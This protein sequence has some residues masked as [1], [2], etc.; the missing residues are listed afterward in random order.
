MPL[1]LDDPA[2]GL[3]KLNRNRKLLMFDFDTRIDRKNSDSHKWRKY[4]DRDII[5]MW[6]ADMDFAAP[7]AVMEALHRRVA[8]GIFGYGNPDPQLAEAITA[9]LED[10]FGWSVDPEWIVWLPGL[11]TGLNVACRSAGRLGSGVV[12]M[13]PIYPPFFTAPK[14]AGRKLQTTQMFFGKNRWQFD[15]EDLRHVIDDKTA[16]FLLCNPHNPTGRVFTRKELE[17]LA[18]ICL[19]AD[20][21]VCSDEIHCDIVL[22][23]GCR[24]IPLASIAPEIAQ[25]TI[26]LM[27]PSKTFNLP[28]LGC[29]F[30]VIGNPKLRLRFKRAMAGIVPHVNVLGFTAAQAAYQ[31]G[32]PW[33]NALLDYLRGNRDMVAAAI[34]GMGSLRMGPVEAT[35]LAWIDARGT[36]VSNPSGLFEQ[37]GVGLSDGADFGAPGYVR[38]NFGCPRSQLSTALDRMT[39]TLGHGGRP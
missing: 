14:C 1:R 8:H 35:Y 20:L 30:A 37:G 31:Y 13:V 19:R 25:R 33:L 11:V 28:G 24:H 17:T 36:G 12:T 38:L 5:P 15:Q 9:H 16:L 34:Q 32:R 3:Q 23:P 29:A 18:E 7:P 21:T 10:S 4:Q 39:R 22:Q 6:V 26:T 27:A 2:D